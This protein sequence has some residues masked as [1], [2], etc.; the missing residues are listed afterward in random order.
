MDEI[1]A[2][3]NYLIG[4]RGL[5][6]NT[7]RAYRT[8]LSQ[9][10]RF[11]E[12]YSPGTTV[13]T[14]DFLAVRHFIG[15]LAEKGLSRRS[16]ARKVSALKQFYKYLSAEGIVTEDPAAAVPTPRFGKKLPTFLTE[17]EAGEILERAV[18]RAAAPDL[19]RFKTEKAR[20]RAAVLALR[21]LAILEVLYGCG[22]RAAELAD[23]VPDRVHIKQGF[24]DVLGKGGR[25]R[26]API[27]EAVAAA[28]S[29]YL[30]AR[31]KLGPK[32]GERHVFLNHRG[33]PLTTRSVQRI[34]K[35]LCG[36]IAPEV[37][38]H[39]WRHTYATH[40]LDGGADI[41]AIQEL[42]GHANVSTTAIYAHVTAKRLR[43]VYDRYHPHA[44][45]RKG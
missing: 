18:S 38:P 16:L 41:R 19:T 32:A 17:E 12:D 34:V 27:G 39:V 40:M 8:D 44:G 30:A 31:E 5:S 29:A 33:G 25:E 9:L 43:D 7:A 6:A 28:L 23:L 22:L 45:K 15:F 26:L 11:L 1:D 36:G 13:V 10:V 21:D 14:A 3:I 4:N 35:G 42:L 37:T 2:Y 24:L 20:E